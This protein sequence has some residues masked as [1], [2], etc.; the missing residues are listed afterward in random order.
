MEPLM[1]RAKKITAEG[2]FLGG[3]PARFE[4]AGR[5]FLIT[6]LS[7]GLTP[8]SKVLEVGCG[9]LRGGYW[10][11][12]FLDKGNYF[13]IEPNEQML[14]AGMRH[15]FE[16]GVLEEKNPRFDHNSDFDFG[17]FGEQFDYVVALSIW[18]HASKPQI[19][20]MLDGFAGTTGKNGKFITTYYPATLFKPDYKGAE[21]AGRGGKST[22][23]K[24][25]NHSLGWIKTE[26]DQRGLVAEEIREKTYQYWNQTWLKVSHKD[27]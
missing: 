20:R 3:V 14:D 8:N 15:L 6:L 26:C 12:H 19:Q 4:I 16:P 27:A 17:V 21:W 5:K 7:E 13:G 1:E 18:T 22:V 24:M 9:C 10:L 11:I 23:H 25:I 2:I